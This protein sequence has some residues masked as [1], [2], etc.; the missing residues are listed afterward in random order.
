MKYRKAAIFVLVVIVVVAWYEFRP[1]RL[2]LNRRVHED[3]PTTQDALPLQAIASGP[4]HRVAHRTN[5]TAT[6]YRLGDGS[7]IL[8][9]TDFKTANGPDVHV[10]LVAANDAKDSKS[11]QRAG[12]IDLG[13]IKGNVGDQNYHLGSDVDLSR[14]RAVSVW[15]KRFHINFGTAAL[16]A[17]HE[18]SREQPDFK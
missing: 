13:L 16:N 7:R 15:C 6:V 10:Y 2:V 3:F 8:R 1:E 4:F 17:D 11:V 12:F 14:Y 5:G 9:F 18:I